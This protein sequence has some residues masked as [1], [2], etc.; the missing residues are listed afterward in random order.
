MVRAKVM[1]LVMEECGWIP[2]ILW[3]Q[4]LEDLLVD[5]SRGTG[6]RRLKGFLAFWSYWDNFSRLLGVDRDLL[7]EWRITFHLGMWDLRSLWTL[8]WNRQGERKSLTAFKREVWVE[9]ELTGQFFSTLWDSVFPL[10]SRYFE[11]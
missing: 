11:I 5:W 2:D 1:V 9:N 8:S 4:T 3:R 10:Y 6:K 7:S